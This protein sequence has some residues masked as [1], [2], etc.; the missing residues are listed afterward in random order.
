MEFRVTWKEVV[1]GS[2]SQFVEPFI[3]LRAP[4]SFP[5]PEPLPRAFLKPTVAGLL[6]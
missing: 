1:Q 3:A 2:F 4:I 6:V 5:G